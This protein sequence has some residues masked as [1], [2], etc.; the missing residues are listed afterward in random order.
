MYFHLLIHKTFILKQ[1]V[2]T[3]KHQVFTS[4][5]ELSCATE[6]LLAELSNLKNRKQQIKR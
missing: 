1:N 6:M 2:A 5:F 3:F 4:P